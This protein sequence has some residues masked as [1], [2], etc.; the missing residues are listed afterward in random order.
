RLP[1][2][3]RHPLRPGCTVPVYA[4]NFVL[5]EYGTG[6]IF[7]CPGHDERDHEFATKYGLPIIP[8]VMPKDGDPAGFSVAAEAYVE[9]GILINPEFLNG[10]DVEAAKARIIARLEELDAGR[11]TTQYRLRDWLVS[12]QRYWGCPI[13]AIHCDACG[14]VP[15]P[16]HD[17][18]VELP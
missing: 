4:A 16:E 12:R 6:A 8:V 13:P 18:P 5:M 17:L 3:A 15:V 14:V 1:L 2:L 7:G 9:D 11:G 10:L